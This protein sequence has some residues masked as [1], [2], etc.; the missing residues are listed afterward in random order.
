M[1]SEREAQSIIERIAA[2]KRKQFEAGD[3]LR[4]A[5]DIIAK[6]VYTRDSHFLLELTQNAEDNSY[7]EG[8]TDR[9]L[10]FTVD[11]DR[12]VVENNEVGFTE[13][14][15]ESL[16]SVG[17]ST[18][19][20]RTLGY[21]GEK[22][23]G[24][25]SVF[26]VSERPEIF[27]SGF[28]F[29]L[30]GQTKIVPEWC[31][32]P[33]GGIDPAVGTTIVLGLMPQ[34]GNR[35]WR[36]MEELEELGARALLF[37]HKLTKIEV[38][39]TASG[40]REQLRRSPV[41]EGAVEIEQGGRKESWFL[42]RRTIDVPGDLIEE[43]RKGVKKR[44][45]AVAFRTHEGRCV[46]LERA[47]VFAF[48]PTEILPG[49]QF[50]A[51]AD[52]LCNASREDIHRDS[53]WNQWL[54]DEL[55]PTIVSG[56]EAGVREK[57]FAISYLHCVPLPQV[58]RSEFFRPCAEYVVRALPERAVFLTDSGRLRPASE[59]LRA[60]IA[61]RQLF[62]NE[63]LRKLLR[64]EVE[65]LN[66]ASQQHE[67]AL[68]ELGVETFDRDH[69]GIALHNDTWL[70]SQATDWLLD[71]YVFLHDNEHLWD[72]E[73]LR[74]SKIVL[75]EGG[76][77]VALSDKQVYVPI[78]TERIAD[79]YDLGRFGLRVVAQEVWQRDPDA[80]DEARTRNERRQ[81]A[82]DLLR[83]LGAVRQD[84]L[85][86][87]VREIMPDLQRRRY[88][89][90][91]QLREDFGPILYLKDEW[92]NIVQAAGRDGN[93]VT[94]DTLVRRASSAVPIP[95]RDE[96][97][98][99]T[100]RRAGEV[101]HHSTALEELFQGVPDIWFA[102]P[103]LY[104]K[105]DP[106]R[107][108]ERKSK[109]WTEFLT[110]CET[111]S[112]LR[113]QSFSRVSL[114]SFQKDVL[115]LPIDA[116][117]VEVGVD[118]DSDD[119]SR[120]I[121]H[122]HEM[123]DSAKFER[124]QRLLRHLDQSWDQWADCFA[125]PNGARWWEVEVSYRRHYARQSER[126]TTP[127]GFILHLRG[128]AW[129]PTDQA[130]TAI[131][132][133]VWLDRRGS[134]DRSRQVL[135]DTIEHSDLAEALGLRTEESAADILQSLR[136]AGRSS[137]LDI[138][139]FRSAF[140]QLRDLQNAGKLENGQVHSLQTEPLIYVPNRAEPLA[141]PFQVVWREPTSLP[142]PGFAALRPHYPRDLEDFFESIG[143]RTKYGLQEAVDFIAT[144]PRDH[145]GGEAITPGDRL[146]LGEAFYALLDA[147]FDKDPETLE[148]ELADLAQS[149]VLCADGGFRR[150]ARLAAPDDPKLMQLFGD[151]GL[152]AMWVPDSL[153]ADLVRR[154]GRLLRVAPISS[155][156][157]EV[158]HV[159]AACGEAFASAFEE[160][161]R[162]LIGYVRQVRYERYRELQ[163]GG[164]L[165]QLAGGPLRLCSSLQVAYK[166]LNLEVYA[167]GAANS[168]VGP[169]SVYV[170]TRPGAD[171]DLVAEDL[172]RSLGGVPGF[173]E[174]LTV[175]L[176]RPNGATAYAERKEYVVPDEEW[177]E[178]LAAA[179]SASA[180][181]ATTAVASEEA[182]AT[183]E[184]TLTLNMKQRG[185]ESLS[186]KPSV[187]TSEARDQAAP[188]QNL[189]AP[190]LG[191]TQ[192]MSP[193]GSNEQLRRRLGPR[194]P[195]RREELDRYIKIDEE[196]AQAGSN[197]AAPAADD[198][199]VVRRA[200]TIL[201]HINLLECF[202]Q[203]HHGAM[204]LF[205]E[206][207]RPDCVL[208]SNDDE[209][210]AVVYV[211]YAKS[212][213]HAG[214]EA[215]DR[216]A[217]LRVLE[218]YAIQPGAL[219]QIDSTHD[220]EAFHVHPIYL[221]EPEVL[222]DVDYYDLND[223][224]FPTVFQSRIVRLN[225]RVDEPV[226]RAERR[227]EQKAAFEQLKRDRG[228]GILHD[229][230]TVL[231]NLEP[232]GSGTAALHP[233]ELH[234]RLMAIGN[235]CAYNSVLSVLYAYRS[236]ERLPDG[237]FRLAGDFDTELK[238]GYRA[239]LEDPERG[240]TNHPESDIVARTVAPARPSVHAPPGSAT[241]MDATP[242]LPHSTARPSEQ[243]AMTPLA[244]TAEV[245]P[246]IQGN[247]PRT[248]FTHDQEVVLTQALAILRSGDRSRQL[249]A[250]VELVDLLSV[251]AGVLRE[252]VGLDQSDTRPEAYG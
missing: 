209:D 238:T 246:V 169:D 84:P 234:Q 39:E 40:R 201:R 116:R 229:V 115:E 118:I 162:P 113:L 109:G 150:P 119:L 204:S 165:A 202:L 222:R 16:C 13:A 126:T 45:V 232:D 8:C 104:V 210:E 48:L 227:W 176:Q 112:S 164:K 184:Q 168:L 36:L 74:Q 64:R 235:G 96:G 131:P 34:Y 93:S 135:R 107:E 23:I 57:E 132:G 87:A 124:G 231:E 114:Q 80:S 103:D 195:A 33:S 199:G 89:S 178:L 31:A 49:F 21:V 82:R 110:A 27:S 221:D 108:F 252:T 51:Q 71:L 61:I 147:A 250:C 157:T 197:L 179:E 206:A 167:P 6:E 91:D 73:V 247:P 101:Y 196:V 208:L 145:E 161:R 159:P 56:I 185:D 143:V 20:D 192:L 236:F 174:V 11:Q 38:H 156:K 81:K 223:D 75:L 144:M 239:N 225:Y 68:D 129:V 233:G 148:R 78:R 102:A 26:K 194:F 106:D 63:S 241:S 58:V 97:N 4:M 37:L 166:F 14:N 138:S 41:L 25:K 59:V 3:D 18:K 69:L 72:V 60:S 175:L 243:T 133:A 214:S 153:S 127:S 172:H 9:F 171:L 218:G 29:G 5:L 130:G 86:I 191:P 30:D 19:L 211:D 42:H 55:G 142:C 188:A 76:K 251:V 213:L 207:N 24:F 149:K 219:L 66:V 189:G 240:A 244:G 151:R 10:R 245:P 146:R 1:Y 180:D 53:P 193:R 217:L 77:L 28:Q 190:Y 154:L 216:E 85:E 92:A 186:L 44:E 98:H 52:F 2:N 117:I 15:V 170:L 121:G 50:L 47:Q 237:R 200:R 83:A 249:K 198:D 187:A 70:A 136:A 215:T 139:L 152:H 155:A 125:Q 212:I 46:P 79:W 54:R 203:L 158:F 226:F 134:G 128:A 220:P 65:Y 100:I 230:Y 228:V 205:D 183:A 7:P 12:I 242:T 22:G 163:N 105:W 182:P 90:V 123:P 181:V 224:G 137:Q 120:L 32:L 95:A 43:K 173:A 122:I 62:P 140:R 17:R 35:A 141:T 177:A 94:Y 248:C 99:V 67:V 160:S 111:A 88:G